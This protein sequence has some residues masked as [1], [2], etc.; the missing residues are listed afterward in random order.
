MYNSKEAWKVETTQLQI[1]EHL[2]KMVRIR[3]RS[4]LAHSSQYC[5]IV[6]CCLV[7]TFN[8]PLVLASDLSSSLTSQLAA[9]FSGDFVHYRILG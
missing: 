9:L 8:R 4:F 7:L 1:R 3:K 6:A 2:A 5:D